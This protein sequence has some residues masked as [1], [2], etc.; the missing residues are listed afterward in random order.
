MS[1]GIRT[2]TDSMGSIAVPSDVYY[3]AQTARSLIHFE[4]GEDSL[5][6]ALIQAFGVLKK[7]AELVN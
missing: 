6:P 2:E 4:I 3:G 5:P 1:S 7:E